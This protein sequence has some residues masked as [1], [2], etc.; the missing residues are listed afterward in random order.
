MQ[1]SITRKVPRKGDGSG[2]G[3]KWDGYQH[4]SFHVIGGIMEGRRQKGITRIWGDWIQK[5]VFWAWHGLA[6]MNSI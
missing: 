1:K 4:N 3:S 6:L 2:L 5:D